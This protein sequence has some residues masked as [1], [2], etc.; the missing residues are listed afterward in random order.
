MHANHTQGSSRGFGVAALKGAVGTARVLR[1][2]VRLVL[3]GSDVVGVAK[4]GSGKTLEP[5]IDETTVG[6]GFPRCGCQCMAH[7]KF[8]STP[9]PLEP[10]VH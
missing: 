5:W 9:T 6:E 8:A 3:S 4:T 1:H 10:G 2:S 7:K